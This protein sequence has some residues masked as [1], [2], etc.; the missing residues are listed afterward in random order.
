MH[1]T[2]AK[3][4]IY[5]GICANMAEYVQK[6]A[7]LC[8][9]GAKTGGMGGITLYVLYIFLHQNSRVLTSRRNGGMKFYKSIRGVVSLVCVM[10][11]LPHDGF[12]WHH[13][14]IAQL[15]DHRGVSIL[16]LQD[17]GSTSCAIEGMMT[18]CSRHVRVTSTSGPQGWRW[19]GVG[20]QGDFRCG[21]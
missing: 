6:M 2:L 13:F 18:G 8:K 21:G 14:S 3:M 5:G 1:S 19:S 15:Q 11:V 16:K 17:G 4:C 9:P 12:R 20:C 7:K 10:T